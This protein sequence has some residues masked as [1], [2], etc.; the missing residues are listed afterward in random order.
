MSQERALAAKVANI[1]LGCTNRSSASREGSDYP[2]PPL[3]PLLGI[4]SSFGAPRI[5]ELLR[6]TE[7]KR[8][9]EVS[10]VEGYKDGQYTGVLPL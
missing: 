5:R 4:V 2:P 6:I 1:I 10:S 3:R 8:Q 7:Y 9:T